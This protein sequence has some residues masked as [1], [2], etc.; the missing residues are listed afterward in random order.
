MIGAI[1]TFVLLYALIYL[2]ERQ[3][4]DLDAFSIATAVVVPTILV[5]VVHFMLRFA[6]IDRWAGLVEILV[7]VVATY[8]VL[9]MSLAIRR[10]R[11]LTYT[12]V[13]LVFNFALGEG[14][15]MVTGAA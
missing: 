4:D 2:F 12:S 7:L 11:A 10:A 13:I 9:T 6:G 14:L 3:R 5:L 15:E 1:F 8:M